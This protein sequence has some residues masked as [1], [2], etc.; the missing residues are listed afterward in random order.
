ML[1]PNV[2]WGTPWVWSPDGA[3]IAF[4]QITDDRESPGWW[5]TEI[6]LVA[7]TIADGSRRIVQTTTIE[8]YWCTNLHMMWTTEGIYLDPRVAFNVDYRC[9][10]LS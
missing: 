8:E 10:D 6:S 7:V 5:E 4:F 1:R 3:R 2:D 9:S